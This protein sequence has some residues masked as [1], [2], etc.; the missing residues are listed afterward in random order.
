MERIEKTSEG[1]EVASRPFLQL[2]NKVKTG[3]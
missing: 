1:A 2:K 3:A